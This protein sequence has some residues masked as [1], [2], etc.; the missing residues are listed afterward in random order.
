MSDEDEK[1]D[2]KNVSTT[3]H[4]ISKKQKV[5]QEKE[6]RKTQKVI[7]TLHFHLAS[8]FLQFLYILKLL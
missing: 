7:I 4:K 1:V 5:N 3:Q 8:I 6:G 2:E